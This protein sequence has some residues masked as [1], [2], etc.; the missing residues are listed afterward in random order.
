MDAFFITVSRH[1]LLTWDYSMKLMLMRTCYSSVIIDRIQQSIS[2]KLLI[3]DG[4]LLVVREIKYT[5]VM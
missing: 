2:K 5:V 3:V 4:M 1:T